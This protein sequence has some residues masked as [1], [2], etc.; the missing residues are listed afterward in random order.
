[1]AKNFY[2]LHLRLVTPGFSVADSIVTRF[3]SWQLIKSHIEKE[4]HSDE[5]SIILSRLL[6][7]GF[8]TDA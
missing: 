6:E 2:S 5:I 1:L 4:F 3:I 8:T 7:D